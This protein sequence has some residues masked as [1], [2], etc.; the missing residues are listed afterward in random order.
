M[1]PARPPASPGLHPNMHRLL[2]ALL[3]SS[4]CFQGTDSSAHR[5]PNISSPLL[6]SPS[7]GQKFSVLCQGHSAHPSS[8]LVYWLA[9]ETFVDDL[10]P[11]GAVTQRS[12]RE[13][14]KCAGRLLLQRK[15]IFR[16]FSEKDLQTRFQC[17]ILDPAGSVRKAIT[18]QMK[19][20]KGAPGDC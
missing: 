1:Q 6:C 7:F 10:Y 2:L 3:C 11:D 4:T 19:S 15:L 16:A 5:L 17:T 9:N 20:K 13:S 8:S 12:T 18:W 14:L